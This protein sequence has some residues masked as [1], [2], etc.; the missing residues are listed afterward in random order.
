MQVLRVLMLATAFTAGRT[1]GHVVSLV[2]W[3]VRNT[4]RYLRWVFGCK[5]P[6]TRLSGTV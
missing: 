3:N 4:S 2:T 1:S 6:G 5:C